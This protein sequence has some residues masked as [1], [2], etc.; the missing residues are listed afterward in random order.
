LIFNWIRTWNLRTWDSDLVN[1]DWHWV[2]L[3]SDWMDST[4][5]LVITAIWILV[6]YFTLEK[7]ESSGISRDR[8]QSDR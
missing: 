8:N 4:I 6:N 1:S 3:D 2:E 7:A 5:A